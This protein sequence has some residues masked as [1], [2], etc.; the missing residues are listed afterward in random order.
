MACFHV[1]VSM[2]NGTLLGGTVGATPFKSA[3][4]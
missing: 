4:T 3:S 1:Y 2:Y